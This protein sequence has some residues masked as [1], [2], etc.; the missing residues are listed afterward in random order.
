M[1]DRP[2]GPQDWATHSPL[3]DPRERRDLLRTAPRDPR[4]LAATVRG[5]VIHYRGAAGTFP[6][7]RTPEI[8]TRWVADVLG[9]LAGRG[10]ADLTAALPPAERFVGC[11]RDFS[12]LFVAALR[13]H[14][15]PA[16]TRVGFADYFRPDF[17]VD[18]VVAEYHDGERWV[19][20]DPELEPGAFPFDVADMDTGPGGPFR[21]AATV[22]TRYRAGEIDRED[23]QRFGVDPGLSLRGPGFVAGYVVFELAHLHGHELLLWDEWGA[24][25]ALDRA[26]GE[27]D[28]AALAEVDRLAALLLDPDAHRGEL[29]AAFDDDRYHPR[30]AVRCLSPTGRVAEVSLA[31]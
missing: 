9:V 22:W 20:V 21:T 29:A 1:T 14:G 2:A 31:R 17:H 27:E 5:L 13:E 16:R 8:D 28:P 4:A 7:E 30:G 23:V 10:V 11:C 19:R 3:T 24:L 26:V 18:H 6:A 12:L 15:V 25:D